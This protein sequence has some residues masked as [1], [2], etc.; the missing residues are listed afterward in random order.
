MITESHRAVLVAELQPIVDAVAASL[1]R[2]NLLADRDVSVTLPMTEGQTL[3]VS[4]LTGS[5]QE[6]PVKAPEEPSARGLDAWQIRRVNETIDEMIGEPISVSM[7]SSV[8][9]LS[10]SHFSQAFR[11]SVGRTPH[12]HVVRLRIERAMKL[13]T[14]T[15]LPLSQIAVATG[16]SDQAHFSNKFRHAAGATPTEWRRTSRAPSR[17]PRNAHY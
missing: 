5:P 11:R 12:A 16:F 13:M 3:V 9:G 4:V 14:D 8:A 15:D 10:R 6:P 17:P 2:R 7:L 1:R